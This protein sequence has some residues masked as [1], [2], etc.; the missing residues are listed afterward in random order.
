[1]SGDLE[2]LWGRSP[3]DQLVVFVEEGV[4]TVV[5]LVDS[6]DSCIEGAVPIDID[7]ISPCLHRYMLRGLHPWKMGMVWCSTKVAGPLS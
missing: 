1:M 4:E 2:R 3:V 6:P 5:F 7:Y